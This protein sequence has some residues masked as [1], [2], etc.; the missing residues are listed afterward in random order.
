MVDGLTAL[1]LVWSL[2][3][4]LILYAS[5]LACSLQTVL[6]AALVFTAAW[7]PTL[8]C[9][10]AV[11]V[12]A[13]LSLWPHAWE[14]HYWCATTDFTLLLALVTRLAEKRSLSLLAAERTAAVTDASRIVRYQVAV[15]YLS[16]AFFKLNTSFLDHRYSCA[17]PYL[18]QILAAYVPQTLATPADLALIVKIAPPMV[19]IGEL[20]LGTALLM[21][22]AGRGG[23]LAAP[24]GVSL[25]LLLHLGI[26][27]TPP[28][29]NIGA[30]SVIMACRLAFFVPPDALAL[31]M[32]L[33]STSAELIGTALMLSSAA[34]ATSATRIA[35]PASASSGAEGQMSIMFFGGVDWSVPTFVVMGAA[36][37]RG[38]SLASYSRPPPIVAAA[39]STRFTSTLGP[40]ML[41][42]ALAHAFVGPILGL[43]DLGASNMYSN[44]RVVGGS[45]HLLLPMNLLRL[46]GATVRIEAST[47]A[48]LNSIHP[49]EISSVISPR[50]R[51]VLTLSGH[52]GRQFN[53]GMGRV[54]GAWALPNPTGPFVRYT[55]PSVQ[56]RRMLEEA[57]EA[58]EPFELEYTVLDNALGDEAWRIGSKGVHRVR[59]SLNGC[60]VLLRDLFDRMCGED[61]LANV[62]LTM[63]ERTLGAWNPYPIVEGM[64]EEMHC[65]GP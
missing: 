42:V 57:R 50:A 60:V 36:V 43:Q 38:L 8:C 31:A 2:Q 37:L 41:V 19:L 29:N 27:V 51:N 64:S 62:P 63:W 22:A 6:V 16:A 48:Q 26:A 44:L 12:L 5:G 61:E 1:A 25:A 55:V 39:R 40:L 33:P 49:G 54:L 30:F 46:S 11:R 65:F 45:N 23:P 7:P 56:L 4:A 32:R 14:S 58:A 35:T 21:A 47:S 9:A 18:A 28:P 15:Y 20:V 59:V 13:S 3:Q 53:W 17:S 34:I 52:S 10:L 24:L